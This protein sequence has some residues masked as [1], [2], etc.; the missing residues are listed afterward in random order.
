VAAVG[1]ADTLGALVPET[2][3]HHEGETS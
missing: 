2:N 1:G 3:Q